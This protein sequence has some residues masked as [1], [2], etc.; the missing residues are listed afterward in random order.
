MR[1]QKQHETAASLQAGHNGSRPFLARRDVARG[2]PTRDIFA[3]Q[4][5]AQSLGSFSVLSLVTDEYISRHK[6]NPYERI[7]ETGLDYL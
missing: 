3:L 7:P 6:Q 1:R 4:R 5:R 2:H